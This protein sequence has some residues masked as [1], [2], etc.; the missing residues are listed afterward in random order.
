MEKL[1]ELADIVLIPAPINGGQ[2]GGQVNFMVEEKTDYS[3]PKSLPIF[4][5]PMESIVGENSCRTWQDAGVRPVIPRTSPIQTRLELCKVV[6]SAF[7]LQE[8]KQYFLNQDRRGIQSQFHVSLDV[9]NGQSL[10]LFNLAAALKQKYQGQL[11]LMGGNVG[12]PEAYISYSKAGFDYIRIGISSCHLVDRDKYGFHYPM[13]SLLL[14]IETIKKSKNMTIPRQVKIIAD[15]GI[16][17]YSDILKALALGAD[18]VMIGKEFARVKEAEG[19]IY[20]KDINQKTGEVTGISEVGNKVL[21]GC[22]GIE[23]KMNG[24]CRQYYGNTTP[25]MQALRAGYNNLEDWKKKKPTIKV[26]DSAWTWI[27]IDITLREWIDEFKEVAGNGFLLS[28]SND[29]AGFKK[30]I[31]YGRSC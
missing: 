13:A 28:N 17:N 7:S 12:N 10:E 25:E 26:S 22:S 6:F 31:K 14:D 29:W 21:P 2:L 16:R 20:R 30:N 27:D 4:T 8:A 24:L 3:V 5:S 11:L 23:A 9:G 18:Y 19:L 1:L 15:G